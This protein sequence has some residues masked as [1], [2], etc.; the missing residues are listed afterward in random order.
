[1]KYWL[2]KTEPDAYSWDDLKS[3][4]NHTDHWDGIRNYAAR[5]H[6]RDMSV[7]DL[8]FFYH[9]MIKVPAIVGIAKVVKE[10]YPD[11]T[12]FDP[13][14]KYFD[15]KSPQDNPRWDMVNIQAFQ[16]LDT[17]VTIKELKAIPELSEMA[18][19]RISRLS[20][21]PVTEVE[22]KLITG[23]RKLQPVK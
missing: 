7:G 22:W 20:V 5:N 1:M 13:D 2:M 10:A 15:P 21:Q 9:S 16:E 18:L 12:Q 11:H 4:P 14:A 3:E 23:M 8:V 17:E 6:M 19:F